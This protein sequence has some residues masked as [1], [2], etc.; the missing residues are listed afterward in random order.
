MAPVYGLAE[1]AVARRAAA[2]GTRTT[3]RSHQPRGF[4]PPRH[5]RT[6]RR[7][8]SKRHRN[9]ACGQP[10]P[11]HEIRIVDNSGREVASARR[12]GSNFVDLRPHRAISATRVKTRELF[13]DGWL[14][15][16]DRAYMANGDVFITGRIKDI[17][18]RAGQHIYPQEIEEAVG[19]V[20]GL[21]KNGCRRVRCG[22]YGL[23]N[24]TCRRHG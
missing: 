19:A 4:E 22:R 14:D 18:I 11:G 24:R 1:C 12:A 21:H 7:R 3:H 20:P 10:V 8:R 16:G 23:R 9:R 15:S 13:H 17:I 2:T 6:R 5:C